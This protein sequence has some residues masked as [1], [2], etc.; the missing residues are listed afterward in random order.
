VTAENR[1]DVLLITGP[2]GSG[3]STLARYI[4]DC[5]GWTCLSEDDY[6][7]QNGWG[8]GPR[9][10][11]QESII[12]RH[13]LRDVETESNAGH[14]V[15]LEFILYR[16]PPNPLTWYQGAL[17]ERGMSCRTIVLAPTVDEILARIGQR[18]RPNDLVDPMVTRANAE[19][20]V[21]I[22]TDASVEPDWIV[23]TS[24][25]TVEDLY[26]TCQQHWSQQEH[27]GQH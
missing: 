18:G 3:K 16:L 14:G 13:V 6:W 9:T 22:L 19:H 17:A 23:H 20:Q 5:R 21:A 10:K 11:K 4:A 24:G 25:M 27:R 1:N 7:V 12:Q 2:A 26:G 15:V 8:S